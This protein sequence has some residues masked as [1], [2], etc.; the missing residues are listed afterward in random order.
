MSAHYTF[1]APAAENE[2][3]VLEPIQL[4]VQLLVPNREG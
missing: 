2:E 3:P 1:L 4:V